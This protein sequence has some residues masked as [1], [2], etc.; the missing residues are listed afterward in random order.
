MGMED[1]IEKISISINDP[2]LHNLKKCT[3]MICRGATTIIL[4]KLKDDGI[5]INNLGWGEFKGHSVAIVSTSEIPKDVKLK[6]SSSVLKD[7]IV[8]D[9]SFHQVSNN[10]NNNLFIGK[11]EDYAEIWKK[12]RSGYG[13]DDLEILS[14][15]LHDWTTN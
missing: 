15:A 13:S 3:N 1:L 6:L 5:G 12:N 4:S 7:F 14:V 8:I 10:K 2:I 9:G 11:L